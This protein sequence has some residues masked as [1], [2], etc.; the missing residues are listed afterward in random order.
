MWEPSV[1]F[2]L[3]SRQRMENTDAS[4]LWCFLT[5][6]RVLRLRG[7]ESSGSDP[8]AEVLLAGDPDVGPDVEVRG[9]SWKTHLLSGLQTQQ[10]S[11]LNDSSTS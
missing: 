11:G 8:P 2:A 9:S 5:S 6:L 4:S 7:V 3:E 10:V 1:K